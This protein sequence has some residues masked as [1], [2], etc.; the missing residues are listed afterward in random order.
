MQPAWRHRIV[1]ET[2]SP[3]QTQDS[4]L[5]FPVTVIW[6]LHTGMPKSLWH[7]HLRPS[8]RV[9]VPSSR[10]KTGGREPVRLH[11]GYLRSSTLDPI[12]SYQQCF[13]QKQWRP[14][15]NNSVSTV[16]K[17]ETGWS[18]VVVNGTCQIPNGNFYGKFPFGDKKINLS[19][20]IP[21]QISGFCG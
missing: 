16:P 3:S 10:G 13:E 14:Q 5:R 2:F 9:A 11:V 21:F 12:I 17:K 4:Y 19:I 7:P 8:L 6:A 18:T 20:Y 1:S 15:P